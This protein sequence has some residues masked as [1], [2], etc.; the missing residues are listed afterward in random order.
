VRNTPAVS[1]C[2]PTYNYGRFLPDC[3]ESVIDQTFD[4]WELIISDDASSDDTEAITTCYASRDARVRYVRNPVRLGMS[5]NLRHVAGLGCGRYLKILCA[6]DWLAPNCLG[7]LH[8]LMERHPGVALAT[9]AEIH[10]DASGAPLRVQFLFGRPVSVIAGDA[11]LDRMARGHG[12]GGNSSFFIRR[13]AYERVGGY[14]AT[15][16]YAP[17]YDLGARLCRAGGYLHTDEPLFYG[18]WHDAA[19]SAVNPATLI[20]VVDRFVVPARLFQPRSFGDREWRRYHRLV[21]SLTARYVF[22]I[23][24][25]HLRGRRQY[26]RRLTSI[27]I[28]HGNLWLGVPLLP[29]HIARRAANRLTR[30]LRPAGRPPE[31]WMTAPSGKASA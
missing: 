19:S 3:I 15:T 27:V 30:T 31:A 11:M 14:D 4:D 23:A 21:A 16:G 17:D 7:S 6:D 25:E 20:D 29:L 8:A 12:F 1:V 26:A 2:V 10:C 5:P 22:N 28:E 13:T 24:L 9:S 18:R